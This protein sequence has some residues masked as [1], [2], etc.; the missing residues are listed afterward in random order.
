M[1]DIPTW[2]RHTTSICASALE[3]QQQIECW[4]K[5]FFPS[6]PLKYLNTDCF[7]IRPTS[8]PIYATVYSIF[9]D[10]RVN[11]CVS[12]TQHTNCHTKV[13][14]A[15]N[16]TLSNNII[17]KSCNKQLDEDI[18]EKKSNLYISCPH[19]KNAKNSCCWGR[20]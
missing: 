16:N 8:K 11:K 19:I 1:S 6:F 7:H 12:S 9:E 17:D 3:C 2:R 4:Y 5:L 13:Q 15:W 20:I 18:T 10:T 14:N